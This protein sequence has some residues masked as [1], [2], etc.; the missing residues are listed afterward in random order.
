MK[1]SFI[2]FVV[3]AL[4]VVGWVASLPRATGLRDTQP[5]TTA[6]MRER[7]RQARA[8]GRTYHI[9]RVPVPLS[10]ISP[11]LRRAVI[12][13]EDARFYHHHG[14]DW[15][16]LGTE[17]HYGQDGFN[18]TSPRDLAAAF[19]AF[20]YY[21]AHRDDV[22]GR[23]TI[24][25]QLAKNLYFGTQRSLLRKVKE[26]IVTRRL[27]HNLTKNRILDLYLNDV[28]WGP[29]IFGAEAAARHYYGKSAAD[30]DIQEAAALA[31]TLPHPLT[32]NPSLRPGRLAWRE[33]MI[34]HWMRPDTSSGDSLWADTAL[35]ARMAAVDSIRLDTAVQP[36][37]ASVAV[38]TLLP[39]SLPVARVAADS[40]PAD[41]LPTP[42]DTIPTG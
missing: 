40:L 26:F 15:Q 29:G 7:I 10:R 5:D 31:A 14:I 20:R 16:A 2:V 33:A 8:E 36:G 9:H 1:W 11:H 3:L 28:E 21:L 37:V 4:A 22:R 24:T 42:R 12:V 34:L 25:E 6:V 13:A 23:S 35:L 30:L 27:E 17:L 32:S 18:L 19:H 39:D 38:D 41:S